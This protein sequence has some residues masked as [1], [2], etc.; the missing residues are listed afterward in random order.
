MI[1]KLF[2]LLVFFKKNNFRP[3]CDRNSSSL[4]YHSEYNNIYF[5]YTIQYFFHFFTKIALLTSS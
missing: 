4:L 3:L 5:L 1:Y 2:S